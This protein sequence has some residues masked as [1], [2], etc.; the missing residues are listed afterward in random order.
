MSKWYTYMQKGAVCVGRILLMLFFFQ[1]NMR[2]SECYCE[3]TCMDRI[4]L[5]LSFPFV[6]TSTSLQNC[7]TV[8]QLFSNI[9]F[10]CLRVVV[11]AFK[12]KG[13]L[14]PKIN[15]LCFVVTNSILFNLL[16][17]HHCRP[18]Q[19]KKQSPTPHLQNNGFWRLLKRWVYFLLNFWITVTI[20][21]MWYSSYLSSCLVFLLSC[22]LF[23]I[24]CSHVWY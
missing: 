11:L 19:L 4:L 22:D 1:Y 6:V 17:L 7:L 20:W 12:K 16:S 8:V 9:V 15:I 5:R 21:E 24:I 2:Q 13:G 23:G 3:H 18:L 14:T 10:Y